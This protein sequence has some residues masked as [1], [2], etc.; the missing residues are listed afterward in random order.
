MRLTGLHADNPIAWMAACG[1]LRLLPG[2]RLRWEDTT[3]EL[4]YRGDILA[5]LAALPA[6]R[7]KSP[8]YQFKHKL[9]RTMPLD[10]W[11]DLQALPCHWALA[12]GCQ[13]E[14]G[15]T[16]TTLKMRPGGGYD[17]VG[18]ARTVLERLVGL[19]IREKLMEA[20]EGPWRYEDDDCV[21]WGWDAAAR[22]DAATIGCKAD[23]AP[24]PGVLGAYWL[25]WEA[26]PLLPTIHGKT[27]GW[28]DG[29]RYPTWSEWL[30]YPE[31]KALML[32]LDRLGTT[33]RQALGVRT[34]LAHYLQTHLSSG[35]LGWAT[36]VPRNGSDRKSS[37]G[38]RK[39]QVTGPLIV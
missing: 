2:A 12:Y 37:G 3:P 30:D 14:S 32:A 23:S 33:E 24:K 16:A 29:L 34:C 31:T 28:S 7:L 20:L 1:A 26:L 35:R 38:S 8:E 15:M 18:D 22:V 19:D 27:L 10:A 11:R 17:M 39:R 4:D 13:T 21:A 9:G 6:E 5:D 25:G 36:E